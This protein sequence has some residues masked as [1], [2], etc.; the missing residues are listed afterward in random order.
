MDG[1]DKIWHKNL[2]V[3]MFLFLRLSSIGFLQKFHFK[4]KSKTG[5]KCSDL[6]NK[7]CR[8]YL[9]HMIMCVH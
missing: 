6:G 8:M 2:P 9:C 5:K 1:V 3:K 7:K 4:N